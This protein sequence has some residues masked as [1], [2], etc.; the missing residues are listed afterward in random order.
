MWEDRLGLQRWGNHKLRGKVS[1][2]VLSA[3]FGFKCPI[4]AVIWPWYVIGAQ[5]AGCHVHGQMR[6]CDKKWCITCHDKKLTYTVNLVLVSQALKQKVGGGLEKGNLREDR[7]VQ[8][9]GG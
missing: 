5:N 6:A 8:V 2:R 9:E 7:W 1:A 4:S 3:M